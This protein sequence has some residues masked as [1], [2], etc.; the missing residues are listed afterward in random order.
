MDDVYSVYTGSTK[1]SKEERTADKLIE[2]FRL[3]ILYY[4]FI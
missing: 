1:T 4:R 3:F 2:F